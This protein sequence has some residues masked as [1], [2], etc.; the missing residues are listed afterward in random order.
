MPTDFQ[1]I[2]AIKKA[3]PAVVSIVGN[4][5]VLKKKKES[6]QFWG[7]FEDRETPLDIS[8]QLKK[9]G[10][11]ISS[12][13]GFIITEDGIIATNSHLISPLVEQYRIILGSGEEFNAKILATD[14]INDLVLL[15]IEAKRLPVIS[16][17]SSENLELGQTAI[18]IGTALG[19]FQNSVSVGVVSGLSRFISAKSMIS[20]RVSKLRGLIQTDAAVNPGNSGGPLIDL[21]GRAIGVNTA[22]VFGAENIGFAIP[23]NHLKEDLREIKKYGRI[24]KPYLGVRY[25]LLNDNLKQ[26][27]NLPVNYGALVISEDLPNDKAVA[28]GSPAHK[29]GIKEFDIILKCQGQ[30]ITEKKPLEEI[31]KRL[32]DIKE[33][34]FEILR[35]NKQLFLK[36]IIEEKD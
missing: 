33:V 7:L 17:G 16:L 30:E 31:L 34:E 12:G 14:F 21:N 10:K 1:V 4:Q 5:Q 29:A 8:S 9:D 28:P 26:R 19:E 24:K 32:D 2:K 3:L 6:S 36:A 35:K 15:K 23:I 11:K 20:G 13:S 22:L 27:N 25:L 18:A